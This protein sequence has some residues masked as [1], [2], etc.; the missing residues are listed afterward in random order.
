MSASWRMATDQ[1]VDK[2]NEKIRTCSLMDRASGYGPEGWGFESLQVHKEVSNSFFFVFK[3]VNDRIRRYKSDS[4]KVIV[5]IVNNWIT[6]NN[7]T[8]KCNWVALLS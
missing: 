1:K 5:N 6:R 8:D 7:L 3:Q 2:I 4:F